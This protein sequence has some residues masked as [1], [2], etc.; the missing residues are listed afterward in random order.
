REEIPS[1]NIGTHNLYSVS[2]AKLRSADEDT[3]SI[4]VDLERGRIYSTSNTFYIDNT[5]Y[6]L[7]PGKYKLRIDKV[8]NTTLDNSIRL[9]AEGKKS[10]KVSTLIGVDVNPT[11]S[12][13]VM[14]FEITEEQ[15]RDDGYH[16]LRFLT[17]GTASNVNLEGIMLVKDVDEVGPYSPSLVDRDYITNTDIV[18]MTASDGKNLLTKSNSLTVNKPSGSNFT[19]LAIGGLPAGRYII[20][21]HYQVNS[22]NSPFDRFLVYQGGQLTVIKR[23]VNDS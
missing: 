20:S 14:S 3:A 16:N 5:T 22:E 15:F 9:S 13:K 19:N 8:S 2:T 1:T 17:S 21:F 18:S 4:D 11:K 10:G 23:A 12:G 7:S 6:N